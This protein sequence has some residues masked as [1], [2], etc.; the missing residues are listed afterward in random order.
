MMLK[1]PKPKTLDRDEAA[2]IGMSALAFIASDD[3]RLAKFLALT[4]ISPG[5]LVA[6]A[7]EP[8]SLAA[9]IEYLCGDESLLLVFSSEAG[10]APER[11]AASQ[12]ILEQG[13]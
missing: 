11:V 12:A 5:D 8:A 4:G 2:E 7:R 6:G 9:V 10:L 1:R 13:N 3:D